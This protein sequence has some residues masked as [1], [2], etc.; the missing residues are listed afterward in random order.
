MKT[1]V[2]QSSRGGSV[3][4]EE[5]RM[6]GSQSRDVERNF[7]EQVKKSR[8]RPPHVCIRTGEQRGLS[9]VYQCRV[10]KMGRKRLCSEQGHLGEEE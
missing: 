2:Q 3:R 6:A 8:Q 4:L 1:G 7:I 5:K 9:A 10:E